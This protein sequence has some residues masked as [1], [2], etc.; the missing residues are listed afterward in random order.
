MTPITVEDLEQELRQALAADNATRIA[1]VGAELDALEQATKRPAVTCL[2]AALWYAEHGAWHMVTLYGVSP[3]LW[4]APVYLWFLGGGALYIIHRT[5]TGA[6]PRD[7]IVIFALIALADL[8]LEIPI[9]KIAGLYTYWG[10]TQP[11][12]SQDFFPLPLWFIVTNRWFDLAPALILMSLMA[13]R[14]RHIEWA[15]PFV[16]VA[17]CYITY[18][19]VTWPVVLALQN[20]AS[21]GVTWAAGTLTIL[22][23]LGATFL[24]AH[25]APRFRHALDHLQPK[26]AAARDPASE[27]GVEGRPEAALAPASVPGP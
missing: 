1:Q 5:R 14:I 22:L 3:P 13:T 18:A 24:G 8:A 17:G 7:F 20:G 19:S 6:Q 2:A 12:Y 26:A 21:E 10:D 4:V 9:I 16:M 11:Y 23:G 15:I 27:A 25:A